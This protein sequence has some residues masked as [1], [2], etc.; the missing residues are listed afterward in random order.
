MVDFPR[1]FPYF[2]FFFFFFFVFFCFGDALV[3]KKNGIWQAY[4]LDLIGI[5]KYTKIIKIF[6]TV[7]ALWPFLLTD[8]R[9]TDGRRDGLKVNIGHSFNRSI[10]GGCAIPSSFIFFTSLPRRG[11]QEIWRLTISLVRSFQYLLSLCQILPKYSYWFE[12]YDDYHIYLFFF[13]FF[14]FFFFL[15]EAIYNSYLLRNLVLDNFI[16]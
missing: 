15:G 11:Y 6:P 13:F 16:R 1:Q 9:R 3:K 5:Y 8:H 10:A 7:E 2:Y 14:F 12:R 4:W